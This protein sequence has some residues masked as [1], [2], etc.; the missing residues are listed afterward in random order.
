[1]MDLLLSFVGSIAPS[2]FTMEIE[3]KNNLCRSCVFHFSSVLGTCSK[4]RTV[5]GNLEI[6]T[7][8]VQKN[9]PKR[10]NSNIV[11]FVTLISPNP[12]NGKR[13]CSPSRHLASRKIFWTRKTPHPLST[14]P[15]KSTESSS[16]WGSEV[17]M[18]CGDSSRLRLRWSFGPMVS[19]SQ[20][21][22]R[23]RGLT[24][25][26]QIFDAGVYSVSIER[27]SIVRE[28]PRKVL[29]YL[30]PFSYPW[31]RK[32]CEFIKHFKTIQNAIASQFQS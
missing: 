29:P 16:L 23:N 8:E 15:K 22:T 1:M 21:C 6:R 32:A 13:Y 18:V 10:E 14:K 31:D 30:I 25:S 28:K 26:W 7:S 5:F 2:Q 11:L 4:L 3:S 17:S 24:Q 9:R 20:L 27:L 12:F 19:S